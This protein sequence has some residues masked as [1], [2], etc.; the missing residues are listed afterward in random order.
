MIFRGLN[1]FPASAFHPLVGDG[2]FKPAAQP[3]IAADRVRFVGEIVALVI[4]TDPRQ[5]RGRGGN[6]AGRL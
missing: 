3:A 4:A 6:G 1:S 5:C 2:G